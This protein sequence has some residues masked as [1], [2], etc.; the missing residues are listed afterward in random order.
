MQPYRR[1]GHCLNRI[2]SHPFTTTHEGRT[3]VCI[4][5]LLPPTEF[6]ALSF[7]NKVYNLLGVLPCLRRLLRCT[8]PS[9][10]R[11][12]VGRESPTEGCRLGGDGVDL[13]ERDIFEDHTRTECP[14]GVNRGDSGEG[15]AVGGV[16]R[17]VLGGTCEIVAL[18]IGQSMVLDVEW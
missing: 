10:V 12:E 3:I 15:A 17:A 6:L 8:V 5:Q 14:L 18:V 9:E 1:L 13:L 2:F 16:G 4:P 11:E 7:Y